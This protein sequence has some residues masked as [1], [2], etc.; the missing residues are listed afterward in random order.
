[1]ALLQKGYL[2]S[3]PLFKERSWFQDVSAKPVNV[4]SAV[5]LTASSTTHTKG[6]YAE[7]IASTSA[8]SSY[9][10]FEAGTSS[11]STDCA[12]LLDISTGTSGSESV[13]VGDIAIGQQTRNIAGRATTPIGIPIKI[14]S[15]T[16]I[17]A[18]I[19]CATASKA[20]T[21]RARLFD[22]GDYGYAPTAVDVIGTSTATSAGTALSGS[23]GT[24]VQITASSANA[25]KAIVIVP[26]ASDAAFPSGTRI[27]EYTLGTGASG[28]E[29]EI[30][31]CMTAIV[32]DETIG[33]YPVY[34]I[35]VGGTVATGTRLSIKH[36]H[37][38][39]PGVFD[40]CLLGIR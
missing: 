12:A 40:V 7:V 9:L 21:I 37:A 6:S 31:R 29:V 35:I 15:G 27:V 1:M 24:W 17:A 28:S 2:G 23:S 3:T 26:S 36:E 38:S 20:Y 11:I 34:P 4:S 25:Y 16:R 32:D 14:A 5:T 19:Q 39:S 30:G 33:V 18:R 8:N 22:M 13:L 10:L